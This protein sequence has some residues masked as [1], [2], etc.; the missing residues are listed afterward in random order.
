VVLLVAG[1]G[2][3]EQR[4]DRPALDDLELAVGQAPFDVVRLPEV[5]LDPPAE[6]SETDG[7]RIGQRRL[8]LVGRVDRELL[9]PAAPGRPPAPRRGRSWPRSR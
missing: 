8:Q 6:P 4:G 1:L 3:G 2:D 5:R 7:L 9:R